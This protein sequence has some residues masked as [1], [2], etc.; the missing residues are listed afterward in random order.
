M[1][2]GVGEK[3]QG[4]HSVR[5]KFAFCS[6]TITPKRARCQMPRGVAGVAMATQKCPTPPSREYVGALQ[7]TRARDRPGT[8]GLWTRGLARWRIRIEILSLSYEKGC[9]EK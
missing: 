2:F 5:R 3:R 9:Q 7:L 8:R 4:R 1:E 6:P